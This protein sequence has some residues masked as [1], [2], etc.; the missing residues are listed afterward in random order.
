MSIP[1]SGVLLEALVDQIFKGLAKGNL[2]SVA[3]KLWRII[4]Q[5][6]KYNLSKKNFNFPGRPG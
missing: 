3:V 4:A 2:A 1:L 6:H 5:S